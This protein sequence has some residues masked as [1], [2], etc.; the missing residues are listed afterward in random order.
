MVYFILFIQAKYMLKLNSTIMSKPVHPFGT[1]LEAIVD[2]V[3]IVKS[4]ID[5]AEAAI[6]NHYII[7]QISKQLF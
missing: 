7:L 6:H 3:I 5:G 2:T 1:G 4:N